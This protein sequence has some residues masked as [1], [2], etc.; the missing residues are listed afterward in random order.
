[1][2]KSLY[3]VLHGIACEESEVFCIPLRARDL[4]LQSARINI[5]T[6]IF[7]FLLALL[8]N[9]NGVFYMN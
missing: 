7:V 2:L 5:Y 9:F 3:L 6:N 1:M 8:L 4:A